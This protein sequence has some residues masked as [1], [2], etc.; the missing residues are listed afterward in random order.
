MASAER[1]SDQRVREDFTCYVLLNEPL[2]ADI[3]EI[4]AALREDYPTL[5]W[6]DPAFPGPAGPFDTDDGA[7]VVW[8]DDVR[9]SLIAGEGR[10]N[11]AFDYDKSLLFPGARQ[12][13]AAH[14]S[15]LSISAGS[16]GTDLVDRFRAARRMTC[17]A[18]LF[19]RLPICTAVYFTS[20]DG[21]VAPAKWVAAAEKALA[22]DF[23]IEEWISIPLTR[24][25]ADDDGPAP[26]SCNTI[27]MAAFN[28]H[29]ILVPQARVPAA[30]V[31]GLTLG[32]VWLQMVSGNTFQD[33]NTFGVEDA[34]ARAR[35]RFL[36]EGPRAQTDTWVLLDQS[37]RLDEK[38]LFGART[39]RPPPE[40][41][42]NTI[43]PRPGFLKQMLRGGRGGR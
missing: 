40:G 24:F 25:A 22:D 31:V 43:K 38:V 18:A 34:P 23:P 26:I 35:M 8:G 14:R 32:A 6:P 37:C 39:G 9:L 1:Y 12:A 13:V 5:D 21:I 11:V 19:A 3:A 4:L 15:Y 27:G 30:E 28:G 29:E 36:P 20:S 42:D 10:C 33:S 7:S 2:Q 17:F 16:A 41:Y